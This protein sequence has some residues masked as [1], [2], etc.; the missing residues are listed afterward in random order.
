MVSKVAS[1]VFWFVVS[2]YGVGWGLLLCGKDG[3]RVINCHTLSYEYLWIAYTH[4]KFV[5]RL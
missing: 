4:T 3:V 1:G 2:E 5:L